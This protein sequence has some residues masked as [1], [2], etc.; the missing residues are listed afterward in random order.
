MSRYGADWERGP[1][2]EPHDDSRF[3]DNDDFT[4]LPLGQE[5]PCIRA[6]LMR[7]EGVKRIDLEVC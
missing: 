2:P 4:P 6:V 7:S 3:T 1:L 5:L